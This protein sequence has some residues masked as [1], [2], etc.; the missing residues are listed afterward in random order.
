MSKS[1]DSMGYYI[2]YMPEHHKARSHGMVYEH[3][4]MAEK[5]I[6]RKLRDDEV[7]HHEDENKLNNDL[8]NLYVFATGADHARYHKTGIKVKVEDY[9][10]SP[11][12]KRNCDICDKEFNYIESHEDTAKYCSKE[13]Q[14]LSRRKS[15]RPSKEELLTLIKTKSF[16]H[17][18][19]MYGVSDNAIRKWCKD[20]DLP[21][22]KKDINNMPS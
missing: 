14:G 16:V 13:C 7:V 5:K 12:L 17:I 8:D 3:V 21:Y 1:I 18:G 6:G 11:T 2:L 22:R 19:K 20:Y 4:V 15:E 10:I 9:Y